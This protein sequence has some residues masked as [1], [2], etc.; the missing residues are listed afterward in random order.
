MFTFYLQIMKV[1]FGLFLVMTCL[2]LSQAAPKNKKNRMLEMHVDEK[3]PMDSM[4]VQNVEETEELPNE[5]KGFD[6]GVGPSQ[7]FQFRA[8]PSPN[9]LSQIRAELFS[10]QK[11]SKVT[12]NGHFGHFGFYCK[13]NWLFLATYQFYQFLF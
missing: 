5:T 9:F 10:S 8:E 7:N 12:K 2:G 4:V 11:F 6:V 13:I 3:I 1:Y